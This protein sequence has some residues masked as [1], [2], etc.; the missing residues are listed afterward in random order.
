M[1]AE[2]YLEPDDE[3][4]VITGKISAANDRVVTI[5][6]PRGQLALRKAFNLRILRRH[7]ARTG[8]HALLVSSDPEARSLAA[9]EGLTASDKPRKFRNK[10]EIELSAWHTNALQAERASGRA[11]GQASGQVSGAS[12]G[13]RLVV[14]GCT[15]FAL[16]LPL[17]FASVLLPSATVTLYPD[18]TQFNEVYVVQASPLANGLEPAKLILPAR[19]IEVD[20][21]VTVDAATVGKRA[22]PGGTARGSVTFVNKTDQPL[23]VLEGTQVS[24]ASGIIFKTVRSVTVPP[25]DSK[26]VTEQVI[27]AKTGEQGNV[28][29]GEITRFADASLSDK[30]SVGNDAALAGGKAAEISVVSEKDYHGLREKALALATEQAK[31]KIYEQDAQDY[32]FFPETTRWRIYEEEITPSVGEEATEVSLSMRG[33][34]RIVTFAGHDVNQLLIRHVEGADL[35]G[36]VIPNTL[37]T[38]VLGLRSVDGDAFSF[39][40]EASASVVR[41]VS[42]SEVKQLIRGKT[43]PEAKEALWHNLPLARPSTI[44]TS[45]FWLNKVPD[46]AWQIRLYQED[47]PSR[48]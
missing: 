35:G 30:I 29:A 42:E 33:T 19:S 20:F 7:L 34:A 1:P 41:R 13:P 5:V 12:W 47:G 18:A 14:G 4:G 23:V 21:T 8:V 6:A 43:I 46:V 31:K 45:P 16:G 27:A 24:T 22:V 15:L 40:I 48:Q 32:S 28:S 2:I 10:Q 36:Q 25:S 39:E 38:R 3:I 9:T 17:F 44:I 11:L 37:R 26:G